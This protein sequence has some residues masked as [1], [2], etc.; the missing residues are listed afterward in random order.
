MK[1]D[2]S[3]GGELRIMRKSKRLQWPVLSVGLVVVAVIVLLFTFNPFGER[4]AIAEESSGAAEEA[5]INA[6]LE[7][8]AWMDFELEDAVSGKT[9]TIRELVGR[10]I[11]LESFAVWCSICLRQQKEMA[12]LVELEGDRIVHIALNTDPNEDLDKVREHA[13]TH[14][15]DWYYAVAPIEMT[16]LLIDEFGL[17]VVNA[18][19]APVVLIAEDGSAEL[20]RS[21]VK[22]A[23]E[24][25]EW[26][27]LEPSEQGGAGG[28]ER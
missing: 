7:L 28:E 17:T 21:G 10:P 3:L 2:G 1:S 24:L 19:R 18:P 8:P 25:L 14:G 13:M 26:T 9:F 11:L 6:D 27:G 16:Q 23:E 4:V 5:A 15:F 22:T 20:L 12:R